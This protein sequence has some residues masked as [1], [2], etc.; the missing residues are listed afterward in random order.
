MTYAVV[1]WVFLLEAQVIPSSRKASH[2]LTDSSGTCV[3]F[4]GKDTSGRKA[5]QMTEPPEQSPPADQTAHLRQLLTACDVKA[6]NAAH[7]AARK[8]DPQF[9]LDLA[10]IT[11][12]GADLKR[13]NLEMANLAGAEFSRINFAAANLKRTNFAGAK[14]TNVNFAGA[15]LKASNFAGAKLTNVNFAGADLS[16]IELSGVNLTGCLFSWAK[17]TGAILQ[18]ANLAGADFTGADFAAADLAGARI[19]GADLTG[20]KINKWTKGLTVQQLAD[21]TK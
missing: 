18:R 4:D 15:D 1:V 8:A 12:T 5:R 20:A 2:A 6:F 16:W 7:K 3:R 9:S 10:G 21:I 13:I 11:L 14:L 17:L 19:T